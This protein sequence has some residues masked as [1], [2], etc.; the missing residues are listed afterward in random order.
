MNRFKLLLALIL[1]GAGIFSAQAGATSNLTK[2]RLARSKAVVPGYWHSDLA[3]CQD[4]AKKNGVPLIAVWS[5]GDL[6]G[7]CVT[8]EQAAVNSVFTKWMKSS[9]CVFFFAHSGDSFGKKNGSAY[10]FCWGSG[11][12]LG[13]FPFV[14]VWWYTN[15]GKTKKLDTAA[16]GDTIDG[17]V[18]GKSGATKAVA[19]FKK[20]LKNFN[21]VAPVVVPKYTG[22]EFDFGNTENDRLEAEL[23]ATTSVEVNFSRTNAVAATAMST[24]VFVSAVMDGPAVT[25]VIYWDAGQAAT[26]FAVDVSMLTSVVQH[27]TLTLLDHKGAKKEERQICAVEPVANSPA[28]PFWIGEKTVD[29]LAWGEWTMDID[30]ATN[31]VAAHNLANGVL[32]TVP[33]DRAYT[34]VLLEGALWCP[35]CKR[36]DEFL[37]D[38]PEFKQWACA[39][40]VALVALDLA[41][42]DATAKIATLLTHQ[43]GGNYNASGSAYLSRKGIDRAE[44][45]AVLARNFEIAQQLRLPNW[46]NTTRPPVPSFFLLRDDGRIA[47][48]LQYFGGVASPTNAVDVAAHIKRFDEMLAQIDEDGEELNDTVFRTEETIGKHVSITSTVSAIDNT[49]AYRLLPAE[50]FGKRLKFKVE[51][52]ED[53]TFEVK[54]VNVSGSHSATITNVTGKLSEG[55]EVSTSVLSSNCCVTV[56]YLQDLIPGTDKK[57]PHDALFAITNAGSTL[58]TYALSTD[59]VVEPKEVADEVVVD[60]STLTMALVSNQVYRITGLA[61]NS[62]VLERIEGTEDHYRALVDGD[63]TLALAGSTCVNQ[64]WNPGKVGFATTSASVAESAGSYVLR[65]VRTGGVSGRA[66]A[67]LSFNAAKSSKLDNLV[68]LPDF[69]EIVWEEGDAAEKTI[70]IGILD[71]PY[72]DGDQILYFD[73]EIGGGAASGTSQFRLSLRDNDRK[74][75]G[76]LAIV[77]TIRPMAKAMTTFVRAGDSLDIMLGRTGGADGELHGTLTTTLGTLNEPEQTWIG[78]DTADKIVT[79]TGLEGAAGKKAKVALVPAKGTSVDTT[80]RILEVTILDEDVP[81]FASDVCAIDAQRYVPIAKQT[82]ALDD[83][84]TAA[85][86]IK[87]YSGTL[88]PGLTWKQDGQNLVIAGVPTKAGAFTAVFRAYNETKAGLTVAVDVTVGDPAV[89]SGTDVAVNPSVV[90]TRTYSDVPVYDCEK[91]RLAGLL[92]LTLPRTGRASAKYRPVGLAAVSLSCASW[93]AL[94][95]DGTLSAELVGKAD[96]NIYRLTVQ[97]SA[98]GTVSAALEDPLRV[99]GVTCEIPQNIWSKENPATD[100][101]GYYTVDLVR[102]NALSGS[103]LATGDGYLTLKMNTTSTIN[104]GKFTFAGK[105]PTGAAVSGTACLT[106]ADWQAEEGFKFWARGLVPVLQTGSSDELAALLQ[107]TPG[108]YDANAQDTDGSIATGRCWYKTVRR[109]VRTANEGGVYWRHRGKTAETSCEAL[110]EAFGCYYDAKEKFTDSCTTVLGTTKLRLFVLPGINGLSEEMLDDRLD[111]SEVD[112]AQWNDGASTAGVNVSYDSKKK[113]NKLA[114]ANTKTTKLSSFAFDQATG[115]VSGAF[116]VDGVKMSFSGVAMPGWGSSDC[117]TCGTGGSEA[118]LRPFITGMAWF[119]DTYRW[120]DEKERDRSETVR[121]SCAISIGVNPGE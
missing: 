99:G 78:R 92:T 43:M 5:N 44:A 85:T 102:T 74:A 14:R 27:V 105:L 116:T 41:R 61:D 32:R 86:T 64:L 36:T 79:L 83:K 48:R 72:A 114:V 42:G 62:S 95:S 119:N 31:K 56:G 21:P 37:L 53:A 46:S 98:D 52:D 12:S 108:A 28:N 49:D 25:N 90:K 65:L 29:E 88:A 76:R 40:K 34:L 55:I 70:T 73:V 7:H 93:S 47:S 58:C 68:D 120:K 6:C 87:K 4:Y 13:A 26:N 35:D 81:G 57:I 101:K 16:T 94:G 67:R 110:F 60:G 113:V 23:G 71:N 75:A 50:S 115:I 111:R 8:F 1:L 10:N 20:K 84:A 89:A 39:N 121:R 59:F 19:W 63:V 33:L 22:G 77:E 103:V 15:N 45:L 106:P 69:E 104:S 107:L 117:T 51:G 2:T 100:F 82:I 54:V 96:A 97:A 38:R 118:Q 17:G 112:T 91:G 18:G 30:V 24:N 109:T 11:K 80:R 9:G 66:T 3:K